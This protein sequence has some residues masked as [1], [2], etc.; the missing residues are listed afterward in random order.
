LGDRKKRD[1]ILAKGISKTEGVMELEEFVRTSLRS[2]IKG[3]KDLREE[4]Y[5]AEGL[6]IKG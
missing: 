4:G 2:I 5:R 1:S 6:S 3:M